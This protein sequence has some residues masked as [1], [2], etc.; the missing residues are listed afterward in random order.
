MSEVYDLKKARKKTRFATSEFVK[1]IANLFGLPQSDHYTHFSLRTRRKGVEVWLLAPIVWPDGQQT[2]RGLNLSATCGIWPSDFTAARQWVRA[3]ADRHGMRLEEKER[4]RYPRASRRDNAVF[5]AGGCCEAWLS[6][7]VPK[8][9]AEAVVR[10]Q[11]A[12]GYCGQD[13]FCH[14]GDCDMEMNAPR[15][16]RGVGGE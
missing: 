4:K 13:G 6:S 2:W 9:W 7:D 8:L 10:C 16:E 5:L 14:Y 12:G 15:D 11:H 1:R 3:W